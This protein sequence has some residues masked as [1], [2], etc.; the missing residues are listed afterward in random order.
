M[1]IRARD[2]GITL[3]IVAASGVIDSRRNR[4]ARDAA[5]NSSELRIQKTLDNRSIR[6][7]RW[8]GARVWYPREA[9][10]TW[11]RTKDVSSATSVHRQPSRR[12]LGAFTQSCRFSLGLRRR[13]LN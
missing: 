10:V 11:I 12:P 13:Q 2:A 5:S 3:K 6:C 7:A 4:A 8:F 9:L 1:R